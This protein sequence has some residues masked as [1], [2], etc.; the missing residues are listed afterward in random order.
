MIVE[1]MKKRV[2]PFDDDMINR[3]FNQYLENTKKE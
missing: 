2:F 1:Q 3:Y